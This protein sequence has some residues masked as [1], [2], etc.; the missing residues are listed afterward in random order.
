LRMI[1][2]HNVELEDMKEFLE[3]REGARASMRTFVSHKSRTLGAL[4]YELTAGLAQNFPLL[5]QTGVV[6]KVCGVPLLNTSEDVAGSGGMIEHLFKYA[7][8]VV[9][10]L[11]VPESAQ[12]TTLRRLSSSNVDDKDLV[13]VYHDAH[14]KC[15]HGALQ[16]LL[17]DRFGCTK[18]TYL[19]GNCYHHGAHA[20]GLWSVLVARSAKQHCISN[21]L[22]DCTHAVQALRRS[23][24]LRVLKDGD[25]DT[26]VRHAR[27]F[28]IVAN[29]TTRKSSKLNN[30]VLSFGVLG[31]THTDTFD[32]LLDRD[33]SAAMVVAAYCARLEG[34]VFYASESFLRWYNV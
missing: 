14:L 28:L 23:G 22:V 34:T 12:K 9:C 20:H 7:K 3:E 4:K 30:K 19:V 10:H 13:C 26:E 32:V 5:E 25:V 24:H 8:L 18:P 33:W 17:S 11:S 16:K 1:C 31:L 6:V 15:T 21:R 27:R 2:M 29:K